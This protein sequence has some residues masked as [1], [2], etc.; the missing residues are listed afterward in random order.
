MAKIFGFKEKQYFKG[1]E[2]SDTPP[3]VKFDFKK[4]EKKDK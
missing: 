1:K 3:D 2:G 4:E